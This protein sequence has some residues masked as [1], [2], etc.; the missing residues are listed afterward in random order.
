MFFMRYKYVFFQQFFTSEIHTKRTPS[1]VT[2]TILSRCIPQW[3]FHRSKCIFHS[4]LPRESEHQALV[5]ISIRNWTC[6]HKPHT[7]QSHYTKFVHTSFRNWTCRQKTLIQVRRA[8]YRTCA[9]IL[10]ELN[11]QA[12]TLYSM[13]LVHISQENWICKHRS[14]TSPNLCTYPTRIEHAGMIEE[15]EKEKETK[16]TSR[17]KPHQNR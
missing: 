13:E 6:K 5:H 1:W 11:R 10:Q 9:Y 4:G 16:V 12:Q 7:N 8:E 14:Y 15:V 3:V 17:K 2:S